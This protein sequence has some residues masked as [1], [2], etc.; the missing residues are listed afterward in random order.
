MRLA[1]VGCGEMGI[2][3][4]VVA[5]A[6]PA[7]ELICLV[8]QSRLVARIAGR[9]LGVPC[10]RSLRKAMQREDFDVVMICTPPSSHSD[11]AIE[12]ACAGKHVLC[13]K[14]L[15]ISL[16]ESKRM[17]EAA[18]RSGVVHQVGYDMR[19]HP[20]YAKAKQV[21]DAGVIGDV[22][23]LRAEA[24][25]GE[26]ANPVDIRQR[27][28]LMERQGLFGAFAVHVMDMVL[29]YGG[30][31]AQL[32][33]LGTEGNAQGLLDFASAVCRFRSGA[34]GIMDF[35][36]SHH[37]IDKP[38]F[39]FTITGTEGSMWIE[40]DELRLHL[41]RPKEGFDAG[42]SVLYGP[43]VWGESGFD[44]TGKQ[45]S[46]EMEAFAAAIVRGGPGS[47]SWADGY[48]V[49]ELVAAM[50][51]ASSGPYAVSLPL[52]VHDR[53]WEETDDIRK[54]DECCAGSRK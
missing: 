1:I 43:Q 15:A 50:G 54:G 20:I 28:D 11:V 14:P 51:I 16:S 47:P 38:H 25:D 37:G 41:E 36:W 19:Y 4:A 13:E 44:F 21:L 39:R 31:I 22:R 6:L 46:R 23:Y 2:S 34:H 9:Q 29:W 42:E 52:T 24:H 5:N 33:S 12:A 30:E 49:D 40:T 3:R 7:Y 27:R 53:V 48:R 45:L 8:E 26:V 10:Y 35:G 18:S 32:A 17:L